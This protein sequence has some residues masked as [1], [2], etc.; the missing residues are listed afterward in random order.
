VAG[1]S[2]TY[3]AGRP[4]DVLTH[5]KRL[6]V[7]LSFYEP[8][9]F[10]NE[11]A[12]HPLLNHSLP[13][14]SI[15]LSGAL[16]LLGSIHSGRNYFHWLFDGLARLALLERAGLKRSHIDGFIVSQASI[17][18][19]GQAL[20]HFGISDS[21]VIELADDAVLAP[22][23]L[24]ASSS[25]RSTGFRRKFVCEWLRSNVV[26]EEYRCS[27]RRLY[28]SREDATERR[29]LN[30]DE[31]M[32]VLSRLGFEKVTLGSKSFLEQS[33]LFSDAAVIVAPHSASLANLVFCRPGTKVL[34]VIPRGRLRSFYWELSECVDLDY[35]YCHSEVAAS[36]KMWPPDPC[37]TIL[38]IGRLLDMLRLMD[39]R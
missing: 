36:G 21:S 17:P 6:L 5:D 30:E 4:A 23:F 24:W 11:A 18:A 27:L 29:M 26:A 10:L 9:M 32:S 8:S 35:Y 16:A 12:E 3:V 31:I 34:D 37:D 1:L 22:E 38:P 28:V 33:A 13:D 14:R 25:L 15:K 19:V 39:V 2:G 20:R 7:D